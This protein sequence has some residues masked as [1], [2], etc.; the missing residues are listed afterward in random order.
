MSSSFIF[1]VSVLSHITRVYLS[2]LFVCK[3]PSK[4][5]SPIATCISCRSVLPPVSFDWGSMVAW[6]R[7]SPQSEGAGVGTQGVL[8]PSGVPVDG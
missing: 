8:G 1:P 6:T 5:A 3:R 2:L 7:L 4:L